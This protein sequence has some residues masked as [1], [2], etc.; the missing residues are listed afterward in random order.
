MQI[1]AKCDGDWMK[2]AVVRDE[3]GAQSSI[4]T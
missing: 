1:C 3:K 2:F 4:Y